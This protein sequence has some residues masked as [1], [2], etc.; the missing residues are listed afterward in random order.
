LTST[1]RVPAVPGTS[2]LVVTGV[3]VLAYLGLFVAVVVPSAVLFALFGAVVVA[4][5][6][7]VWRL[8]PLSAWALARVQLGLP[9][10][11]AISAAALAALEA[12]LSGPDTSL[13]V[14]VVLCAVVVGVCGGVV[15]GLAQVVEF[16]RK[17]PVLSRGLPLG[18]LVLPREPH[19]L[20]HQRARL[21]WPAVLVLL[22]VP[23]L[24]AG[25]PLPAWLGV[26]AAGTAA[27]GALA[28]VGWATVATVETRRARPRSRVPEAVQQAV[29]D[30]APDLVLYYGGTAD[31][32]YQLE[33]WLPTFEASGHR[34]LVLLRD[35]E[36]LRLLRPTALPVVC[37]PA[38]TALV[39]FDLSSVRGALFVSNAATNIHLIRKGG[40]RTAF[41]GH[42]D[43]D[44]AS[45]R[46]PF[47]K[48]YD[49]IWVAGPAG[50][51][52]YAGWE[53]TLVSDRLR[54]V[55]RPQ[56]VAAPRGPR[57]PGEPLTVL[58]APT[59]EGWGDEPYH[60]SLPHLGVAVVRRL[61]EVPGLRVVYRPHPLTGTRDAAVR[62]AHQ[63]VV[64]LLEDAGASVDRAPDPAPS[65]PAEVDDL[66]LMTAADRRHQIGERGRAVD[67][68]AAFWSAAPATTHRVV[69]GAWPGLA[70][71]FEQ[72][73][74]LVADVSSVVSDWLALDRPLALTNPEGLDPQEC[75]ARWPSSR[76]GLLVGPDLAGLEALVA[77]LRSGDDRTRAQRSVERE[78]LLGTPPEA[79]A[80]RFSEALDALVRQAGPVPSSS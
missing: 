35:R 45:S 52:R 33:M 47:T 29:T 34:T 46:S 7:A 59:W 74:A 30:L 80:E 3:L 10:R 78:H 56:A 1:E 37:I 70:S 27:V 5:E 14:L 19:A 24:A 40:M 71:C 76:A 75:A 68:A 20:L 65:A 18:D 15:E 58:Y 55:G 48:V 32:L 43:S 4:A 67:E 49:E 51:E 77:D 44:K 38:G 57:L 31:A 60:S 41:I 22:V 64:A 11:W 8:A 66:T 72:S 13:D 25:D 12:R 50:A 21:L 42:G 16:L 36:A 39:A 23:A 73:D 62:R 53:T 9:W 63:E 17:S 6:A 26:A 69:E 28:V 61:L 54:L 2:G 79:G